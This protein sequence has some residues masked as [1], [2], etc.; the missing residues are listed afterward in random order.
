MSRRTAALPPQAVPGEP[1]GGTARRPRMARA[2]PRPVTGSPRR[3]TAISPGSF[4]LFAL[5][6]RSMLSEHVPRPGRHLTCA[7]A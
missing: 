5:G 4:A 6:A 7:Y 1:N 3:G 2:G